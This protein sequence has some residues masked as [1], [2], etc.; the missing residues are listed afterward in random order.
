M[1]FRARA[2]FVFT[3][4]ALAGNAASGAS[5]PHNLVLFIPEALPAIVQKGSAP[6]LTRLRDEGVHFGSNQRSG[7]R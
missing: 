2:I 4:I 5:E 3:L 6:T 7:A 1:T